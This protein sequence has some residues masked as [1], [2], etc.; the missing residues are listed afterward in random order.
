MPD[1][2]QKTRHEGTYARE[3]A[4]KRFKGKPDRCYYITYRNKQQKFVREKIGWASEGYTPQMA[5]QIRAERIRAMR[6]GQ[7]LPPDT[8]KTVRTLDSAWEKEYQQ[9]KGQKKSFSD[10]EYRYNKHIAPTLGDRLLSGITPQDLKKLGTDL[11]KKGLS[12]QSIYH[13][14]Q[15]IRSIY[16]VAKNEG[17]YFGENPATKIKFPRITNSNRLRYLTQAESDRLLAKIKESSQTMYEISYISLYTGLRA[18]EIFSLKWQDIDLEQGIINVLETK[19]T[20]PRP[21]YMNEGIRE[22]FENKKKGNKTEYVFPQEQRRDKNKPKKNRKKEEVS[23]TFFRVVEKMGLN[24][25]VEDR[26]YRVC[27]HTLRHTF[28]SWLAIRGESLQTIQELMGH[29]RISQTQRYAHLC[30][31]KKR[32]AVENLVGPE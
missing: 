4:K 27:F 30:P 20:E 29:K 26:R 18:N 12:P 31:N 5:H 8:W 21:A 14:L 11:N 24:D 17:A 6:H 9:E 10:D 3:S 22:I 1:N 32:Q 23:K 25:G 13:V 16:N 15:L 2:L 28:G 19:N 7:E